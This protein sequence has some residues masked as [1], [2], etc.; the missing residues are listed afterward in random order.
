MHAQALHFNPML[1][2]VEEQVE[3]SSNSDEENLELGPTAVLS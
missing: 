3:G 2:G 1:A